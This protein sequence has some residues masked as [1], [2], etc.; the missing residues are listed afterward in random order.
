MIMW[1]QNS[2]STVLLKVTNNRLLSDGTVL[3]PYTPASWKERIK[4]RKYLL[5]YDRNFI[6]KLQLH[7]TA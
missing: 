4:N 2:T 5:L 1:Y 7:C 6:M 3:I